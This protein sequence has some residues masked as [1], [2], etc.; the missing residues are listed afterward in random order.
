MSLAGLPATIRSD[1]GRVPPGARFFRY[2]GA[3]R[4]TGRLSFAAAMAIDA[5]E[6]GDP[7]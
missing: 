5:G 6:H 3:F 2:A 1:I 7:T 4:R